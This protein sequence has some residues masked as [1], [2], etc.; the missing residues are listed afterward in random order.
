MEVPTFT[1]FGE[2]FYDARLIPA[3][4]KSSLRQAAVEVK[5]V[6]SLFSARPRSVSFIKCDVEGQELQT[7]R[8]A[9][10][11]I[12]RDR[13]ML[14]LE[15]S[16]MNKDTHEEVRQL[17]AGYDYQEFWYEEGRLRLWQ[18]G[19]RPVDV[20]F[21]QPGHFESATQAGLV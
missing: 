10:N 15:I 2:S 19:D 7:L 17:L 4:S 16:L 9:K 3:G 6:D 8:G 12:E 18:A 14:L 11:L 1:E 5:T 13:P 20:F 21:F